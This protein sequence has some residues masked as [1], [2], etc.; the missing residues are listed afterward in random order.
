MSFVDPLP[1]TRYAPC[2]THRCCFDYS[3]VV[4]PRRRTPSSSVSISA[5]STTAVKDGHYDHLSPGLLG[6]GHQRNQSRTSV[7]AERADRISRLEGLEFVST[8]RAPLPTS[9]GSG[10][11]APS[12]SRQTIP[13]SATGFPA[14]FP[15]TQHLTPSY[16]DSNGQPV[17]VSTV[18]TVNKT[19]NHVSEGDNLR[20]TAGERDENMLCMETNYCETDP[21]MS[22]RANADAMEEELDGIATCSVGGCEDRT[23]DGGTASLVGF[24]EEANSTIS[25][26]TYRRR[27][28]PRSLISQQIYGL[29]RINS[30]M[31]GPQ[32][33]SDTPMG[34]GT[35]VSSSA[36]QE[37]HDARMMDGVA[38]ETPHPGGSTDQDFF[39]DTTFRWPASS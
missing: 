34:D 37:R 9:A 1:E 36:I 39:V 6:R 8:L 12:L 13:T 26:P 4:D 38:A 33:N 35:P 32:H 15:A 16:F 30:G 29:E 22:M 21:G 14:N 27:V 31:S 5:L 19:E 25:G 7:E 24:G 20:A 11:S 18:Q 17:A 10:G 28:A 23:S 3:N 2:G